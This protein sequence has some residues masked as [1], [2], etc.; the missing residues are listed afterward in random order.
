MKDMLTSKRIG[1]GEPKVVV[2]YFSVGKELA[3]C[4]ARSTHA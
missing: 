4:Q 1:V 2:G 3:I